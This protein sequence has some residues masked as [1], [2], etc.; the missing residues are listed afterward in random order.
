MPYIHTYIH[1]HLAG[2]VFSLF[3]HIFRGGNYF[4][5]PWHLST[6]HRNASASPICHHTHANK[7]THTHKRILV[8][9]CCTRII[10]VALALMLQISCFGISAKIIVYVCLALDYFLGKSPAF[11]SAKLT[12]TAKNI[13]KFIGP[14]AFPRISYRFEAL[15]Y[16]QLNGEITHF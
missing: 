8:T 1:T 9:L 4:C 14:V 15:K 2:W 5:P 12:E 11:A 6:L 13:R 7:H 10:I 3:S 16:T